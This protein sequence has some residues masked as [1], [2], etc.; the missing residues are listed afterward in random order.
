MIVAVASDKPIANAKAPPGT[1]ADV[2]IALVETE[3][4]N[5]NVTAS[6][7]VSYFRF[8]TE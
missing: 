4:R 3:L 1:P 2:L 7:A 6:A 5:E 8:D